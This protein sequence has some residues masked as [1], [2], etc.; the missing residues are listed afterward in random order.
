MYKSLPNN[1]KEDILE[2]FL[3][4]SLFFTFGSMIF[5]ELTIVWDILAP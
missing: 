1:V 2:T 4:K 3:L 5:I